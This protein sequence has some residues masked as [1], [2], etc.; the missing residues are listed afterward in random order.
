MSWR[1]CERTEQSMAEHCEASERS[2]RSNVASVRE[3]LA[4]RDCLKKK[5]ALIQTVVTPEMLLLLLCHIFK[6]LVN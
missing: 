3:A 5:Q 2:E 1:A 4:K 6:Q